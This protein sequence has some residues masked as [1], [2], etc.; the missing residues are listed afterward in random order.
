MSLFFLGILDFVPFSIVYVTCFFFVAAHRT[1]G[2]RYFWGPVLKYI[3]GGAL[4][5]GIPEVIMQK[6][7]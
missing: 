3:W 4:P 7:Q 5:T 1:G 6:K 2:L